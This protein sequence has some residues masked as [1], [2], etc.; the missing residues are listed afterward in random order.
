[1]KKSPYWIVF[2]NIC[3]LNFVSWNKRWFL[4]SF[5][6]LLLS[7]S[8]LGLSQQFNTCILRGKGN[9]VDCTYITRAVS[10]VCQ[11]RSAEKLSSFSSLF[12]W[13]WGCCAWHISILHA[14]PLPLPLP[15]P[16]PLPLPHWLALFML[17]EFHKVRAQK[18]ERERREERETGGVG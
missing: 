3:R 9:I 8:Q 6:S 5:C 12:R 2:Y 11:L 14:I 15:L 13:G 10:G 16:Q 18:G 4:P 1:M 7:I 17:E